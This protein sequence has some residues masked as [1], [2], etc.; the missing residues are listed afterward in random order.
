VGLL[1]GAEEKPQRLDA[2]GNLLLDDAL[3]GAARD[4]HFAA[5]EDRAL[6]FVDE[7]RTGDR[8]PA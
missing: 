8:V 7:F 2:D 1:P 3:T 4:A 5:L 6:R